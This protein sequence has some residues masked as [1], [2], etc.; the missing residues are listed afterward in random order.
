MNRG[1]DPASTEGRA[2]PA[3]GLHV[4]HGVLSLE[5]GGLERVVLDLVRAGNDQGYRSSVVCIDQRGRLAETAEALGARVHCL[6]AARD[7][8]GASRSAR[9]LFAQIRPDLLHTHQIGAL[10]HLGRALE[11]DHVAVVHTEHSDH[12]RLA[13]GFAARC[14]SRLRWYRSGRLAQRFCCVSDDIAHSARRFGTLPARKVAVVHNG[15]DTELFAASAPNHGLRR[16]LGIPDHAFVFGTVG[17]LN[18]VKRQDLL[19]RA[20]ARVLAVHPGAWLMLV[21]DG[22]ERA[23]LERVAQS[24]NVA[25]RTIFTGYQARTELYLAAMD[26]FVLSSRHEGLPLSLLEAWAAGLPVVSSAVGGVVRTVSD[27]RNGLLF[28]SGDEHAL[29]ASMRRLID[30]PELAASLAEAGRERVLAH[31]SLQ[32]MAQRYHRHYADALAQRS[33]SP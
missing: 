26:A 18:E 20:F 5:L 23:A 6:D 32:G 9:A 25:H 22:Q 30:A 28:P 15:I 27:G 4:V 17:R 1:N 13:R 21:G 7:R 12:P 10:W 2:T 31:Y 3:A 14:R 33:P 24:A 29:A 19:I 8:A 11:S 16:A